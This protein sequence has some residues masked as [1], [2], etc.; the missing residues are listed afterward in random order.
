MRIGGLLASLLVFCAMSGALSAQASK[1]ELQPV[2]FNKLDENHDGKLS[3]AEARSDPGLAL[4]FDMLDENHDGYLSM[5]E[6]Q[7]WPRAG[8]TKTPERGT[9]PGGSSGAQH[10]P[11]H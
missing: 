10:L 9:V 2:D 3:R 1:P 11:M 5:E 4:N 8:Q 6:F 7:Q